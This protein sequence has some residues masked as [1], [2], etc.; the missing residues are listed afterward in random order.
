M[1]R[2]PCGWNLT[3]PK[4]AKTSRGRHKARTDLAFRHGTW[5]LEHAAGEKDRSLNG[6]K[7]RGR[8]PIAP[9]S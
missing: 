3:A 4:N 6:Q 8:A 2:T 5:D 7:D 1:K 9:I